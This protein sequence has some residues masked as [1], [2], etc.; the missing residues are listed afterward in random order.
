MIKGGLNFRITTQLENN[1]KC[2]IFVCTHCSCLGSP[3]TGRSAIP[4]FSSL[5]KYQ[6]MTLLVGAQTI[7]N[8]P[9]STVA[10]VEMFFLSANFGQWLQ[11]NQRILGHDWGTQSAGL[12]WG[13]SWI[14]QK[15][16]FQVP[17]VIGPIKLSF[18]QL[19]LELA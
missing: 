3:C 7:K 8:L 10:T 16:I 2:E 18:W 15:F 9:S 19:R 1:V 6:A 4:N 14:H 17:V 5:E 13:R 11:P 12:A